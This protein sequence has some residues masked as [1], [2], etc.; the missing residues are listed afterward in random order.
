MNNKQQ[1]LVLLILSI[2]V[3]G[4][5]FSQNNDNP[6]EL[7]PRLKIEKSLSENEGEKKMGNPFDLIGRTNT[8][9]I[10]T[11]PK[12]EIEQAK[13]TPTSLLPTE[14]TALTPPE[15]N[16]FDLK[17]NKKKESVPQTNPNALPKTKKLT[18]DGFEKDK[19]L[20]SKKTSFLNALQA[21]PTAID[22]DFRQFFNPIMIGMLLLFTLL[23]TLYRSVF[24]KTYQAFLNDNILRIL[25][26]ERGSILISP[27]TILYLMFL[28]NAGIFIFL[29]THY[30]QFY[31]SNNR[32]I[33]LIISI[34]LVFAIFLS[35]HIVLQILAYVFPVEKEIQLYNFT[36]IVFGIIIGI[37]LTPANVLIAYAPTNVT[38]IL[39]YITLGL[40]GLIYLFR[41]LRGLFLANKFVLFHKFHFLLYICT[42][43]LVPVFILLKLLL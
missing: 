29:L 33:H 12:H 20:A 31:F 8:S 18:E 3:S 19:T 25:H 16:P 2:F 21:R 1:L 14:T 41:S 27:Y 7:K 38:P 13:E 15:K 39:V 35:K 30:L 23:I 32:L 37:L 5:L 34:G 22:K 9:S 43:E 17:S 28:I 4:K 40:I 6:F 10:K 24:K 36:I 11:I 42:V 26:R